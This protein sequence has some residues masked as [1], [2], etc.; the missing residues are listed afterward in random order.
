M[1]ASGSRAFVSA[2]VMFCTVVALGAAPAT[3]AAQAQSESHATSKPDPPADDERPDWALRASGY[4]YVTPDGSYLQPTIAVDHQWLHL[5]ARYNY[6]ARRTVSTWIGYDFSIG[7]EVA[8]EITP[9][10]GAVFG[11][12]N[13][14]A[15]GYEG[16]LT[17]RWLEL[18]GEGEYVYSIG[19]RSSSFFYIWSTLTASPA[20]WL[21]LGLVVQRTRAYATSR[22]IQRG[23]FVGLSAE[24]VGMTTYVFNPDL[25]S[26]TYV[27]ALELNW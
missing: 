21:R 6:E 12:T 26:R 5:E 16:T 2:S 17:W 27:M 18:Y 1:T 22:E 24:H 20:D 13:G 23:F 8:L 14:I 9:M 7:K 4:F 25:H 15:L 10:F 3:A 19:D 11:E